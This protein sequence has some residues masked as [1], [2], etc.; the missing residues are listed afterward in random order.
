MLE[1]IFSIFR[2][3]FGPILEARINNKSKKNDFKNKTI[4]RPMS[5]TIRVALGG[6]VWGGMGFGGARVYRAL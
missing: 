6:V 1:V 4:L 2:T 5:K 3:I